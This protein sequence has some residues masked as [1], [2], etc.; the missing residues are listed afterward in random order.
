[1]GES[2]SGMSNLDMAKMSV[3]LAIDSYGQNNTRQTVKL[4]ELLEIHAKLVALGEQGVDYVG[5]NPDANIHGQIFVLRENLNKLEEKLAGRIVPKV[6]QAEVFGPEYEVVERARLQKVLEELVSAQDVPAEALKLDSLSAMRA[7][8][9]AGMKHKEERLAREAEN[10]RAKMKQKAAKASDN[11]SSEVAGTVLPVA[12]AAVA[13][14]GVAV[15]ATAMAA[16]AVE[17]VGQELV[18][19]EKPPENPVRADEAR[20]V[21]EAKS[22]KVEDLDLRPSMDTKPSE[23]VPTATD[24]S[25]YEPFKPDLSLLKGSG[26]QT[27]E[28]LI[29]S[30]SLLPVPEHP[31]PGVRRNPDEHAPVLTQGD[32]D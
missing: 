32:G 26:G 7:A 14:G 19:E 2:L 11:S 9:V 22:L 30:L 21:A 15:A 28:G 8:V 4:A 13:I 18:P 29:D 24:L 23:D 25:R 27:R 1:V 16:K 6:A 17:T 12:V 31:K 10:N 20:A 5:F 3:G